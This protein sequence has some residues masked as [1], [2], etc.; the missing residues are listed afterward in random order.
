M[1][2][3][4][5]PEGGRNNVN[6]SA[7]VYSVDLSIAR[8]LEVLK[9]K[10]MDKNTVIIFTSDNGGQTMVTDNHP[11]RGQK[12]NVYEGGIRVP[13]F[14]YWPGKVKPATYCDT[15][16]SIVDYFP[17]M[18]DIAGAPADSY[19]VDGESILPLM[20]QKGKLSRKSIFWHLPTYTGRGC[21]AKVWQTPAS[22]IRKGD[23]K[24]IQYFEEDKV[25]LFNLRQDL[26]EQHDV[27]AQNKRLVKKLLAELKAWQQDVKAPIPSVVNPEYDE[28]SRDWIEEY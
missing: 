1:V 3:G 11:L 9:K 13:T 27:A 24:L 21:N 20:L 26:S 14:V 15:P 5:T 10:G 17:T 12:G 8:M 28:N 16:I 22:V 4:R 6:Y 2:E 7:M 23:W 25:E 18:A 19:K